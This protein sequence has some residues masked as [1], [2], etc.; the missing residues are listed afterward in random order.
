MRVLI[1]FFPIFTELTLLLTDINTDMM[2]SQK[3]KEKK[4][5]HI[6]IT[7]CHALLFHL[8]VLDDGIETLLNIY[9]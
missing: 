3:E 6:C 9:M 5:K 8:V 7:M 4:K 2:S 1:L